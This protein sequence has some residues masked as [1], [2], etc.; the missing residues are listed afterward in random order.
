MAFF[1]AICTMCRSKAKVPN[2]SPIEGGQIMRTLSLNSSLEFRSLPN[3]PNFVRI[4]RD[5]LSRHNEP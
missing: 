2:E 4:N 3:N 5:T 1:K